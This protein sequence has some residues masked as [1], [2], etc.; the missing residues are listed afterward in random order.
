[1]ATITIIDTGYVSV[2]ETGTQETL[3]A[4]SSRAI[5]LK[6]VNLTYARNANIDNAPIPGT[7]VNA[8]LNPVSTANPIITVKGKLN[9][10]SSTDMNKIILFDTLVRGKGIKLLYY[11]STDSD[12]SAGGSDGWDNVI[13]KLGVDNVEG[14]TNEDGDTVVDV[15][16]QSG[17]ELYNS[18]DP[19]PH[20]HIFVKTFKVTQSSDKQNLN[21]TIT[22]EIT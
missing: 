13:N 10:T 21:Y 20:L 17:G 2:D 15:H 22:C 16:T 8:T 11:N 12:I 6:G 9:R 4:N 14:N 19:F 5:T 3:I 7:E 1:M 18:G